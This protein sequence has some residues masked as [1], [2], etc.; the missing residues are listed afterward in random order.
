MDIPQKGKTVVKLVGADGNA[1]N[2]IGLC[3]RAARKDGWSKEHID[4]VVDEMMSG[5][6]NNVLATAMKYF[7]VR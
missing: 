1:F 4:F 2:I 5:D 3:R 7:D 6:Y